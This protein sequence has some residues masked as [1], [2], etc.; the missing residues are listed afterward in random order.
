M[1]GRLGRASALVD[2]YDEAIDFSVD[3]PGFEVLY[4]GFLEDGTRLVHMELPTQRGSGVWLFEAQSEEQRE[5]V[6]NQTGG[7]P[8]GVF[9]T[10]D[11]R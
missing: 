7:A 3:W 1:L 5:R 2:D 8:L 6:R 4:D 11:S 9:Y 10:D